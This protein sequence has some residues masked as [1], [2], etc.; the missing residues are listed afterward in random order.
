MEE[1]DNLT[2]QDRKFLQIIERNL[3]LEENVSDQIE[4]GDEGLESLCKQLVMAA[5]QA[6]KN[7]REGLEVWLLTKLEAARVNDYG[8]VAVAREMSD[9]VDN[10]NERAVKSRAWNESKQQVGKKVKKVEVLE[11]PLEQEEDFVAVPFGGGRRWRILTLAASI[12]LAVSVL[13]VLLLVTVSRTPGNGVP[14]SVAGV[15]IMPV[16]P[17]EDLPQP[18]NLDFENGL[19]GWMLSG[20]SPDYQIG[21]D[22]VIRHCGAGSGYISSQ[23]ARKGFLSQE[24]SGAILEIY[25]DKRV[26]MSGYIKTLNVP[27]SERA[28]MYITINGADYNTLTLGNSSVT[29]TNDWQ[30]Y[31]IVLDVPKEAAKIDFGL[32][33]EG[34]GQ[35]WLDDV[36]FEGVG[37]TVPTTR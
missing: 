16:V 36:H 24:M 15:T 22:T 17:K 32:T 18:S 30:K 23:A 12:I 31:D 33:L 1:G 3:S 8:V 28:T 35:V 20:Q 7:F 37:E 21:L 4:E 26:R 6:D 27:Q 2:A 5:P 25:K 10:S 29:G 14:M 9:A 19:Q 11:L 34:Q 13:A